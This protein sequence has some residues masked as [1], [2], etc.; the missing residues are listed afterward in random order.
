M[1]KVAQK[2]CVG[3]FSRLL[4]SRL[5]KTLLLLV[6]LFG[7]G[8]ISIYSATWTHKIWDHD[9]DRGA[10]IVKEDVFGDHYE[11]IAYLDQGWDNSD[12]MWFYNT[13][14]GSD[15][16]PYDF[17][18]VLEQADKP[19]PFRAPE[20]MNRY[21]YLPQKATSSNPDALPVGM[22]ADT[23]HGKKFMGFTCAACHTS[24]VNYKNTGIR[25]DGGQAAADMDTFMKEL[26]AALSATEKDEAKRKRFVEAVLK[27]G[28]YSN[29]SEV[30]DD[31]K[32]FTLRTNVYN[33]INAT[34]TAYGYGRL[35]AFGRI[36]NRV[37]QH[38]VTADELRAALKGTLTE[39]E[40]KAVLPGMDKVLSEKHRDHI[41]ERLA[42]LLTPKQREALK[43]QLFNSPNAPVSYPFLW[44][45]PQHDYLQWNGV[46][47]NAGEGPI[48]RNSGEVIGVF[49][50]LDW[51]Q[52]PGWTLSSA[53]GGQGFGPTH[54]SFDSSVDLHNL[55]LLEAQLATL[56][57]PQW[58][59]N[60]LP[61]LDK[62]R[63]ERGAPLFDKLCASCHQEI[64][65]TNPKRHVIAN[66]S[67][68]DVAGT[69]RKMAL[70]AV[71]RTGYAGILTN[72]YAP[73]GV[74]NLYLK[75][76]MP[77]AAL[78][79]QAD[80]NVVATPDP[81]KW[82]F[83]RWAD[84]AH[85]LA[86][87]YLSNEVKPSLKTGSFDADTNASPLASLVAYKGRPLN[88]IWATAPYLHNGSVPTLYDLL[89]PAARQKGDPAGTEYRPAK[90]ITGSREF[91]PERVGFKS[92]GY[93]GFVFDTGSDGNGNAGH[94]YGTRALTKEQRLDLLEYLKSL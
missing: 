76:R 20:H 55:R 65:R 51:S 81:D 31:L 41:V 61:A 50:T 73:V 59:E 16:V 56:Q 26:G 66:F 70:N 32:T 15:L 37:L 93:D 8:L 94:E 80:T 7:V 25:I 27:R 77:V 35:D 3:F 39:E 87:T 33:F 5:H 49:G 58:P 6:L 29:E 63:V 22:V 36:F 23:Y 44:D 30:L 88:G 19:V 60:I 21:R 45:T 9:A 46:A 86:I 72:Q 18:I 40:L 24:Q 47:A 84:W 62:K 14:Q 54:I 78:L 34:D 89:L 42:E 67:K 43:N 28:N 75:D 79:I 17:F 48:G 68:L 64:D 83:Q 11:K 4:G 13:T 2:V 69:D 92:Q 12:S 57:S 85:D 52:E 74:G 82:F 38:V 53:I 10:A 91:D 90:F 71:T 1:H